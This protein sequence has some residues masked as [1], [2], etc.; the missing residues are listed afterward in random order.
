MR[1]SPQLVDMRRY[2]LK[3]EEREEKA[4]AY[5]EVR[6]EKKKKKRGSGEP[7]SEPDVEQSTEHTGEV[8]EERTQ[9]LRIQYCQ[10]NPRAGG[11]TATRGRSIGSVLY[12]LCD[13]N[14]NIDQVN[15]S[16]M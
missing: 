8:M 13:I 12:M 3:V 15:P 9:T 7:E 16:G 4:H 5:R 2:K 10:G 1:W 14:Q 11:M 6:R